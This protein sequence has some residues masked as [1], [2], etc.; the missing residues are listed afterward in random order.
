ML[1]LK[2]D[3]K[4]RGTYR[5]CRVKETFPDIYGLV[6]TVEVEYRPKVKEDG[7]P[8]KPKKMEILRVGVQRLALI[9]AVEDLPQSEEQQDD[10]DAD[11]VETLDSDKY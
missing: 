9:Q 5:L 11:D 4:I 7:L 3:S 6:R 2:Y 1:L 10:E 8:Y